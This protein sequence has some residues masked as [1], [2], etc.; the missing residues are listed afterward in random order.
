V[1]QAYRNVSGIVQETLAESVR[2]P[3]TTSEA[4]PAADGD[5]TMMAAGNTAEN[6]IGGPAAAS[7]TTTTTA[8]PPVDQKLINRELRKLVGRNYRGLR[9]LFDS[10][11]RSAIKVGRTLFTNDFSDLTLFFSFCMAPLHV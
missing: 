10:E 5:Q 8:A 3:T 4:A 7:T 11:L 2:Q 9:R 1:K 6:E